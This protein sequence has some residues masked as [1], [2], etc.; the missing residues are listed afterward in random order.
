M[1]T[2]IFK[3]KGGEL[4]K[5]MLANRE[6]VRENSLRA[7][8][9]IVKIALDKIKIRDSFN[10]RKEYGDIDS[11]AESI[12][13]NGQTVAGHVDALADGSFVLTDGHRRFAAL[14][15]LEDQG[16]EVFFKAIVNSAKTTEEQRILQMFTTQ[17]NKQLSQAEVAELIQRLIN[18]GHTQAGVAKKIGRTPAYISQMLSFASE[19]QIIKQHVVNG[20]INV[21]SVLKLQ[22]EI[23]NTNDRVD[24]ISKAVEKM[25]AGGAGK[26]V[27]TAKDVTGK[28]KDT[29]ASSPKKDATYSEIYET[30][31]HGGIDYSFVNDGFIVDFNYL[32]SKLDSETLT[33]ITDK[34]K[35][36]V[37]DAI[38]ELE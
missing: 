1:K 12:A 17:D 30:V 18:L 32:K 14:K 3:P 20:D 9:E 35:D 7:S 8:E 21:G 27:V 28:K 26:A 23:P 2:N 31:F 22:K 33:E 19:S 15:L 34:I 11:L 5:D 10:V 4:T 36:V 37:L 13:G 29:R 6:T 24:A 38:S 25:K 16:Y